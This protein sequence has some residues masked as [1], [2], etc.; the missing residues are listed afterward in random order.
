MAHDASAMGNGDAI[1]R[2]RFYLSIAVCFRHLQRDALPRGGD[3]RL[4]NPGK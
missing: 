1:F 4:L 2:L 3:C